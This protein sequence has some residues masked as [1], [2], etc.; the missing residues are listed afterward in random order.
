MRLLFP[1]MIFTALALLLGTASADA[2][3]QHALTVYGEPAKYPAGFSHFAYTN[4]RAPKGGSMRR[5]AIEI[6]RFDHVLPYIDKGIGVSQL[7]GYIYSPLAQRSLDEPYTV[8]GL[9]AE[10]ME[11]ADDGLWLRFYLNPKARFADGKPITAED[12]RYTY[13]L[14]M[15]QGSLRYRTQ[16][17]DVKDVEVESPRVIRFDFKSNENRTLPLDIAALPVLPEHWWKSRDFAGG[18]GY[19]APLGSGPYKVSKVDNGNSITFTRDADWWGKDLPVSRGLYNFDRFSIEYFGDTD[20]ARQVLRGGAYDY[21]REF[22]ATG[23]SIGYDGPAL[24]DGRLQKAHLAKEAPQPAQG[25]VFNLQKPMFQDRRVRQALAMLWDFEW[26]NRQMMRDLYIR[27]QSFFS[28]SALAARAL[29]DAEELKIL[30]PLRGQIPDEVFT[31]VFEAPKTDGSGL[32][33][34]KQLQALALLE[35]AGWKPDGDT[36]VNAD[37][38]PLRFTFLNSQ[39][40]IE[41]LLLPY[42]RNLAQIG[43]TLEIRRIDASQYVNRLMARDYDMIV[44][45]YPVTTSPGLELYNY[46]GSAAANDPGSSNLMVLKNPAVDSLITGLVKA[47]TQPQ[48]LRYA[49][50]LDRVL[51]WNY[52]WIP[53]YYP[54]G[55]STVWWNRFGMPAIPASNDEAIE[56][57]WE[58]SRTPLTNE[59]M[60]AERIQRGQPGGPH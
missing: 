14:L 32:I 58:M 21:N 17:A 49:H 60:A 54:P 41:R 29:P 26:S 22:S 18:G 40:G 53:N 57:W 24:D 55:T 52:Y 8:Y 10:K 27:Q 47:T 5:S 20:V 11:R 59:Q 25:F 46:F 37:G 19:E 15:T 3:P 56:S 28:N 36:L 38:E 45:G 12:V 23:F 9:V 16:F 50:A 48:M 30:E 43:I 31:Q 34:D 51:Q 39:S 44:T 1:S 6:G 4:P 35:A 42:K 13:N 7:D 2:A 33:R